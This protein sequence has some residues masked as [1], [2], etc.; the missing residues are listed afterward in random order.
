MR[1]KKLWLTVGVALSLLVFAWIPTGG[2]V[3]VVRDDASGGSSVQKVAR[4]STMVLRVSHPERVRGIPLVFLYLTDG[5]GVFVFNLTYLSSSISPNAAVR[6]EEFQVLASGGRQ[7]DLVGRIPNSLA[8]VEQVE[9]IWGENGPTGTRNFLGGE[10]YVGQLLDVEETFT[11]HVK[12]AMYSQNKVIERFDATFTPE[13]NKRNV[14][15][16]LGWD[17]YF[18]M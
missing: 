16:H 7:I 15:W 3:L 10:I 17:W 9:T 5:P 8:L 6:F 2:V 18:N 12:G 13:F 1:R 4:N 11:V 14:R